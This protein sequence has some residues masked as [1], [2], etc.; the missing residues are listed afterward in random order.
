[1]Q[2][3]RSVLRTLGTLT[4]VL[5][6]AGGPLA[7]V[8]PAARASVGHVQQQS[9]AAR[10]AAAQPLAISVTGMT[11]TTA[12]P[13]STVTV[14]GN[15]ANHSGAALPGITVEALTSTESFQYPSQM[16]DFSNGTASGSAALPLLQ[17]GEQ[18]E[19]PAA[20]PNGATVRWS[21]SFPAADYYGQ[22][23]VFPIQVQVSAPSITSTESAR[24]FLP[25]WPGS[26]AAGQPKGLRVSWVWPLIDTPQQGA[27]SQT[28]ATNELTSSVAAGGRLSTL[29]DAG[30]AWAQQDDLTWDIDPAL[31]S[32]VSLMT[33]SYYVR[34]DAACTERDR[35]QP[36]KAATAWLSQLKTST[37]GGPAFLTPYANVDVAA[38]SHAGLDPNLEAAYQLGD[39]VA[40]QILPGTFGKTGTGTGTGTGNG[41]VLKAAWPADGQADAGVLTSLVDDGGIST[42]ILSSDELP[43]ALPGGADNALAKTISGVGTSMSV[44]LA[45]SRITSLLSTASAT[46]SQAGQ[47]ALTQDYLAQTAMIAAELPGTLRSLVVAPPPSWDPSPAE[48]NALLKITDQAPWLHPTGL[49]ALSAAAAQ[50]TSVTPVKAKQVSP[51]ELNS[52]YTSYLTKVTASVNVFKDLLDQPTDEQL[53]S[54]TAALAVTESSAWRGSPGGWAKADELGDFVQQEEEKVKLLSSKKILLTGQSGET[55]VSVQNG[56]AVPIQVKVTASTPAGSDLRVEPFDGLLKMQAYQSGTVKLPLRSVTIGGTATLQ[57]QLTT[58]DGSPLPWPGQSQPLSVEVTRVGRFLLAIIGGALGILVL[59]SAYRLRRKRL[60]RSRNGG[61]ADETAEAGGAG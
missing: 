54:L 30:S 33:K 17:A 50:L 34:G 5:L 13:D 32:D 45:N 28:L 15:L 57:L 26:E 36:S 46:A 55:A 42:V 19:V 58:Q 35:E 43:S 40:D 29:L 37:A 44:L 52:A 4:A 3:V 61:S 10:S 25:F 39:S 20:V 51:E 12:E 7:A 8:A 59:T 21:V 60:A 18:Y 27:C 41:A 1:M 23:G 2:T 22:F 48:A 11:P 56:L 24:T 53:N 6:A 14:T 38:L 31:L 16:T 9:A 49:S 47:F